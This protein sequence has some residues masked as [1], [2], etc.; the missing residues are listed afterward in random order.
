MRSLDRR[1]FLQLSGAAAVAPFTP[2]RTSTP[3]ASRPEDPEVSFAGDGL[4]LSPRDY[5]QLLARLAAAD[6]QIEDVYGSGGAVKR[7]E[8][9]FAQLTG[10]ERAVFVPTGTL[11]N[12]LAIAV[13]A[14]DK[15]KVFVQEQSHIYRDEA[16]AAQSVFG[17]RLMPLVP[18]RCTFTLEDL[19]AAI[20]DYHHREVFESGI[21]ALAIENPVRRRNGEVF[22]FG[23]MKRVTAYAKEQGIG[24]H[25]DG[26]RLF[27]ASAYSGVS[28]R[29]YA[30][31]FDT[32]YISLYKYFGAGAGAV[33]CGSA[34][35]MATIPHLIKVHGGTMLWNWHNAAVALHNLDGFVERYQ[36]AKVR[37]DELFAA[38]NQID[39]IHIEPLP[40]G[41]NIFQLKLT[42][43]DG[44]K[45]AGKLR[46]QHIRMRPPAN[47]ADTVPIMV[48]ESVLATSND[49]LV[50]AFKQAVGK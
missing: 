23:E 39:G 27:L 3:R 22:D 28:V 34:E 45:F 47:G 35:L 13:L 26:A 5:A 2:T 18:D 12:Q 14:R 24:T 4:P 17:K 49:R 46:E 20:D 50:A 37:A 16:D 29:D 30:A 44:K 32:V 8:A 9:A 15:T 43:I 42:G 36:R 10:K 1:S 40:H 6:P 7:L 38:L 25:L 11:A 19:K 41:S 21:G 33:L 48:N 31:L